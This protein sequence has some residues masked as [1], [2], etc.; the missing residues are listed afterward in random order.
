MRA[1]VPWPL[2][3]SFLMCEIEM[4]KPIVE[5]CRGAECEFTGMSELACTGHGRRMFNFQEFSNHVVKHS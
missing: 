5:S 3:L 1:L 2:S 4:V